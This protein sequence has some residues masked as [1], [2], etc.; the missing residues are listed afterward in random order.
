[1]SGPVSRLQ[2][3]NL[4]QEGCGVSFFPGS[5]ATCGEGHF[6]GMPLWVFAVYSVF[7]VGITGL[8]AGSAIH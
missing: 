5:S 1:V 6:D 2:V 3:S 8:V 4:F 7:R